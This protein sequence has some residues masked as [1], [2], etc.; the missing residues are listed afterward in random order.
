MHDDVGT[1]NEFLD[2]LDV[3][4]VT[5]PVLEAVQSLGIRI[6]R[7]ASHPDYAVDAG[8]VLEAPDQRSADV[9]GR[10]GDGDGQPSTLV[11]PRSIRILSLS[12]RPM[13]LTIPGPSPASGS[14]GMPLVL[15]TIV[16][17]IAGEMS[18][19]TRCS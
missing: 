19:V 10:A 16:E 13:N 18:S 7:A 8:L 14:A 1:C 12:F 15:H 2:V 6:E 5:L 11:H 17:T 3:G 9:T 4:Y